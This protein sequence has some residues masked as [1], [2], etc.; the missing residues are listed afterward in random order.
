MSWRRRRKQP[1]KEPSKEQVAAMEAA[2][3]EAE[4]KYG[5]TRWWKLGESPD[6]EKI[7]Q[8]AGIQLFEPH[9]LMEQE[10]FRR[11]AKLLLGRDEPVSLGEFANAEKRMGLQ[12]T[13]VEKNMPLFERLTKV[14]LPDDMKKEIDVLVQEFS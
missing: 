3:T 8:R 12:R 10:L 9:L 14:R 4:E 7:K 13:A 11:G 2:R 5:K 6:N 1:P